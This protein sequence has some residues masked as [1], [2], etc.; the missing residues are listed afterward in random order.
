LPNGVT[1]KDLSFVFMCLVAD[2]GY[3]A[4]VPETECPAISR[5]KQATRPFWSTGFERKQQLNEDERTVSLIP[6]KKII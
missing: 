1:S 4:S 2:G 5:D 3:R 6:K